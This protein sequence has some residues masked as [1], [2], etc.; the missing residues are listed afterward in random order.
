M[1]TLPAVEAPLDFEQAVYLRSLLSSLPSV[2]PPVAFESKVLKTAASAGLSASMLAVVVLA[3]VTFSGVFW[4]STTP[5]LVVVKTAYVFEFPTADI[6]N[7]DPV[8]VQ[9]DTRY[10]VLP[11]AVIHKMIKKYK[12]PKLVRALHGVAGR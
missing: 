6:Y 12:K 11:P 1:S 7:L 8:L 4:W 3:V 9:H 2:P 5:N 10:K